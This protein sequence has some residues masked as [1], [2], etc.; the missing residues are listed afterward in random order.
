MIFVADNLQI[1]DPVIDQS[2]KQEDPAPIQA[3][4]RR[5]EAAGAEAIDINSGPMTKTPEKMGFMVA[6]VQAVTD[7]PVLIDT[8]NPLAMTEGLRASRKTSIINGFSLEPVKLA[9]ILPLAG[10]FDV[11][12]IGYLLDSHSHV[13]PDAAGRLEVAMAVFEAAGSAG[14]PP[15]RLIIDPVVAPAAW[16]DGVVQNRE[17]LSV[18]RQLPDLIGEPVRTI[19][20]LSNLTTGGAPL[21]K[22]RLLERSYLP[23]L[24]AAG[25]SFALMNVLHEETMAVARACRALTSGGIFA[26][27]AL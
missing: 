21:S 16:T 7:L 27:E 15:S 14:V 13:P 5:C 20:G 2:V 11:E 22:R 24:A 1:T 3:L 18:I 12:I 9:E 23:M 6:A 26:W 10:E 4:V 8:A 25:L 19:G 17:I